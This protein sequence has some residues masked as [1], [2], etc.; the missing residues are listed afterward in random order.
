MWRNSFELIGMEEDFL[1]RTLIAEALRPMINKWDLMK[2]RNFYM[3]K[4]I[5]IWAKQQPIEWGNLS[6]K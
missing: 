2:L 5:I 4:D 1:N 3:V 6:I